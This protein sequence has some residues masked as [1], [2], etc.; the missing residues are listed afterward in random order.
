MRGVGRPKKPES[1][2]IHNQMI[3]I[4]YEDYKK[5]KKYCL[6]HDLQIKTLITQLVENL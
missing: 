1:E 3:S 6:N 2:K 5:I 4:D